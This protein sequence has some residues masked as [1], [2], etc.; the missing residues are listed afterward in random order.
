MSSCL[1]KN[2]ERAVFEVSA[3]AA[4]DRKDSPVHAVHI[5]DANHG[6]ASTSDFHKAAFDDVGCPQHV[7]DEIER[8]DK[9]MGASAGR[10]IRSL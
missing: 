5:D 7:R 2:L 1:C 9:N 8:V 6:S 3:K 10:A 4:E